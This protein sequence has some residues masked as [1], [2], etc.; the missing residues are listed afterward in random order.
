[1]INELLITINEWMAGGVGIAALGC[2]LWCVESCVL[3]K[4][5]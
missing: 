1:M 4:G 3:N 5:G 2:F